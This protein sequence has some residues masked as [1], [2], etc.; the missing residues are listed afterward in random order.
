VP[1]TPAESVDAA[2]AFE[3]V[4]LGD[5][6]E[7]YLGLRTVLTSRREDYAAFD[8]AFDEFWRLQQTGRAPLAHAHAKTGDARPPTGTRRRRPPVVSLENWMRPGDATDDEMVPVMAASDG[9]TRAGG[10]EW[11]FADEYDT[12]FRRLVRQLARRLSM[13]PSRRWRSVRKGERVD[14]RRTARRSLRT[15]GDAIELARRTRR[16]RRAR[17]VALCD[18][19]GSMHLYTRFLLRFLHAL[20]NSGAR[21]ETFVFSTRISRVT[22]FLHA[23]EYRGALS[24]VVRELTDWSGGTLIGSSLETFAREWLH[25]VDRRTVVVIL[26]DGW[27]AGDPEVLRLAMQRIALRAGRVVWLNP[28]AGSPGYTPAAR[29]M[30]AA[31]PFIGRLL[32]AHDLDSLRRLAKEVLL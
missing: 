16:L 27:D 1:V 32:P 19:S 4:D 21:V 11:A 30:Q 24:Q 15:G 12:E 2:R 22:P 20:Q 7:V 26:S 3:F 6:D 28:L 31:L 17:L 10:T 13:R 8:A 25:V 29:G 9:E 23:R 5:R 14:L 18:V